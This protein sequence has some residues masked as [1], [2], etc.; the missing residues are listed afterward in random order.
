VADRPVTFPKGM[1]IMFLQNYPIGLLESTEI[2]FGDY[3]NNLELKE[4]TEKYALKKSEFYT[5]AQPWT[6]S[7][8]YKKGVGPNDERFLESIFRVKLMEP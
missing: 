4:N 2:A 6:W 5:E 7:N 1:P 3:E 8:F